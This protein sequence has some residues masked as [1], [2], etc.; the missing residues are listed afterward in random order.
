MFFRK[1]RQ[2][3]TL[4]RER[5]QQEQLLLRKLKDLDSNVSEDDFR[6]SKKSQR[7]LIKETEKEIDKK[8][9]RKRKKQKKRW[10]L[11]GFIFG[12]FRAFNFSSSKTSIEKAKVNSFKELEAGGMDGKAMRRGSS[13]QDILASKSK[14]EQKLAKLAAAREAAKSEREEGRQSQEAAATPAPANAG[15]R[16]GQLKTDLDSL[17]SRVRRLK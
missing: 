7:D 8:E 4:E 6:T 10:T 1:R 2:K 16:Y 17:E 12:I 3:K 5:R 13:K 15:E 9:R 14:R 11:I